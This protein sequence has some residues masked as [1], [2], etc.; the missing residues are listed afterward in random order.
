[1][2]LELITQLAN[3][4]T[5]VA[6]AVLF[7]RAQEKR[8]RQLSEDARARDA[9]VTAAMNQVVTSVAVFRSII[10]RMEGQL[11]DYDVGSRTEVAQT[12]PVVTN[13]P[14]TPVGS[15]APCPR[16]TQSGGKRRARKRRK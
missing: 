10:T 2:G 11:Y 9:T 8:D 12:A 15:P 13:K 14:N 16:S 1:M 4:S 3:L 5:G 7:L 6:I